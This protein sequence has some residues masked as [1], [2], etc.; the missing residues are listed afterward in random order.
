M[1]YVRWSKVIISDCETKGD[2]KILWKVN[3][4]QQLWFK[5]VIM[6]FLIPL[7]TENEKDSYRL[8]EDINHMYIYHLTQQ[9]HS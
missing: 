3:K 5:Q 7:R 6:K 9:F 4:K 1:N 2:N 8:M